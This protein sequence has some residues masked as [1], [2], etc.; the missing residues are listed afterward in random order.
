MGLKIFFFALGAA[1]GS[2][3]NV[4][5][6]RMPR[7][8]SIIWPPSHC[9]ACKKNIRWFDNIPVLSYLVLRGRCRYC[10]K[11][12]PWQYPLVELLTAL[13]FLSFFRAFGL[14]WELLAYL[15]FACGLII[16]T[17]IDIAHRIIPD[18]ISVGGVVAGLIFSLLLPT[19]QHTT[20]HGKSFLFS[21]AGAAV[22]GAVIFVMGV[23]GDFIFKKESVGGG[24]V[25]LLAAIGAFLGWQRALMVFFLAPLFGA[26]VG[27]IVKIITKDSVIPYGP[28]LSLAAIITLF[29]YS[30][31]LFLIFGYGF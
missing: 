13:V 23:I 25:K 24:D 20:L 18:E 29:W 10:K 15:V 14:R 30:K 9:P 26:I 12:I 22:G 5:I 17:F 21:L 28:F 1:V 31:I 3:L 4:C 6:Y 8:E 27:I 2:F 7:N 16:A 11:D 19:L